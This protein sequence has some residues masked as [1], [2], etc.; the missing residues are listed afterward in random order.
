MNGEFLVTCRR[1]TIGTA[2]TFQQAL[3]LAREK[4]ETE[5]LDA[6]VWR[7]AEVLCIVT[8]GGDVQLPM[9]WETVPV[10]DVD[11]SLT[12]DLNSVLL[13]HHP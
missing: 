4:T 5:W 7:H 1:R 3:D 9:S 12:E 11:P 2:P 10:E 13:E 6:V 8:A